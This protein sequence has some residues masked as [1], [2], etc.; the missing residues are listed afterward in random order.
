MS[1]QMSVEQRNAVQ[2][3]A[4]SVHALQKPAQHPV[5]K[6]RQK[7]AIHAQYHSVLA[8]EAARKMRRT[9]KKLETGQQVCHHLKMMLLS[10]PSLPGAR[11]RQSDSAES[12][13]RL[14]F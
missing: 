6:P 7:A 2:M 1:E 9:R 10:Q 13:F 14:G 3:N 4:A 8:M 5:E 11:R 12:Q